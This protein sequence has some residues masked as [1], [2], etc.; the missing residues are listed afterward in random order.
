MLVEMW[1]ASGQS[2]MQMPLDSASPGF[3]GVINYK[4]EIKN[5]NYPNIRLFD[6]FR[7]VSEN[8]QDDLIGQWKMCTSQ[9]AKYF[10]AVAY[11]LPLN[12]HQS[13]KV[14]IGIIYS[15]W[16][17]TNAETWV[18]KELIENDTLLSKN[19]LIREGIYRPTEPG[20][21]Y[22]TMIYP[23]MNYRIKGVIWYQGESNISNY[24]IY[25]PLMKTLIISWRAAWDIEFPFY[26][27]QIAPF[28]YGNQTT[29]P[30]L[31]EAKRASLDLPGTGMAIINDVGD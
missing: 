15:S 10:S 12:L 21:A 22:N 1:L 16:G 9:N 3:S 7:R 29:P 14:P 2:N 18:R 17:G 26:F 6:V 11:F 24:F 20:L 5:A 19:R 30:Y 4:S 27:T 23:L 25:K 8:P 28:K 13:L 31:R